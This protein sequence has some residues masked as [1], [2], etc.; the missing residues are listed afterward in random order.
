MAVWQDGLVQKHGEGAS[1]IIQAY[2]G[3][4][5][6]SAGNDI[7]H[8][9]RNLKDISNYKVNPKYADANIKQQAGFSG[10]LVKEARDNQEAILKGDST[11]TRTTD[12]LGETNNQKHDHAKVDANGNK[13][14]GSESQMKMMKSPEELAKKMTSKE[15]EKYSDSPMDVPTEQ[16]EPTKQILQAEADKLRNQ[17]DTQRAKGNVDKANELEAK[18]NKCEQAK[19]NIRDSGVTTDDAKNARVNPEKFV[20]KEVMKSSHG[21]GVQAA[22]GAA[23]VGGSIT[24]AQNLFAV[25]NGDK[26]IDEAV[27]DVAVTTTKSA[28]NGYVI[29]YSGTAIKSV[30][31][32]SKNQLMR[33]LGNTNAPVMI[34]TAVVETG[35]TLISYA[36]GEIDEVE[37]L[38]QLGEK[39]TGMVAGAY[40]AAVGTAVAGPVGAFIGGMIGYTVSSLL[41][42]NALATFKNAKIARERRIVI[43]AMCEQ[44]IKQMNA[45]KSQL[46]YLY[47]QEQKYRA[48]TF[49][50]LLNSMDKCIFNNDVDGFC[51]SINELGSVFGVKLQ[52]NN[53]QEFDNFMN[54][55]ESVLVF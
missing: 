9:G 20:A 22:K 44:A 4:R 26:D 49:K 25:C 29:G 36:K 52:F 17:A 45:Y 54:D 37:C 40:G 55:D 19:E 6:D 32:S 1:Q 14:E 47:I 53:F 50:N 16:V 34:A 43:E 51:S 23:I 33:I 21:A 46:E 12:G 18:A 8:Q 15:W 48:A 13:I 39:G 5:Y 27:M 38:E 24:T 28:A 10:E 35:K 31:H 42:N 3:N 11:R 30:M 41:Y 2:T 7:G